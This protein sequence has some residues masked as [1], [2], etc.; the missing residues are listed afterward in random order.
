MITNYLFAIAGTLMMSGWA[1]LIINVLTR[2]FEFLRNSI[3]RLLIPLVLSGLYTALMVGFFV[4]GPGGYGSLQQVML[5]FTTEEIALAGWIHYLA[6]DLFMGTWLVEQSQRD[7]VPSLVMLPVL[8][9]T[10]MFGPSG[11]L[12]YY[13]ILPLVRPAHAQI[14]VVHH[15]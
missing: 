13:A 1:L 6:F 4:Q 3:A 7:R 14:G 8:F 9:C 10:L 5:L 12:A 11:L 2:R 15:D